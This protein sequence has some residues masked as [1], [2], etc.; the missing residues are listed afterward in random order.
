MPVAAHP[1]VCLAK[2]RP[3]WS[4]HSEPWTLG[5]AITSFAPDV[6]EGIVSANGPEIL[7]HSC[8]HGFIPIV[9]AQPIPA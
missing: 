3:L 5:V 4:Q 7:K 2:N 9:P 8:R 6:T 1:D